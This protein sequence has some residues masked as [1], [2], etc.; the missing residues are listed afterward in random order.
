MPKRR[1]ETPQLLAFDLLLV[2]RKELIQVEY[3]SQ[4]GTSRYLGEN[5]AQMM[6]LK[7]VGPCKVGDTRA[8]FGDGAV[9]EGY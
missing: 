6:A 7:A 3:A 9:K 2:G 1:F 4:G 5:I 8:V